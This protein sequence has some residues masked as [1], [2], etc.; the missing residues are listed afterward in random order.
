MGE[1]LYEN[2]KTISRLAEQYFGEDIGEQLP[3]I[4]DVSQMEVYKYILSYCLLTEKHIRSLEEIWFFQASD[5][6]KKSVCRKQKILWKNGRK[7]NWLSLFSRI[8]EESWKE[9]KFFIYLLCLVYM[10]NK[11]TKLIFS[12]VFFWLFYNNIINLV[13]NIYFFYNLFSIK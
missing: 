4:D 5:C 3:R 1:F 10:M 11:K 12:F 6:R 9:S 2:E 7:K 13:F 8:Y